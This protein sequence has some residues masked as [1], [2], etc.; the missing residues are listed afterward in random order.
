MSRLPY[1]ARLERSWGISLGSET[2]NRIFILDCVCWF[3]ELFIERYEGPWAHFI[4]RGNAQ[5]AFKNELDKLEKS[6]GYKENQQ[7]MLG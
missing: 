4:L 2:L 6:W 7:V 3:S 5:P 1:V